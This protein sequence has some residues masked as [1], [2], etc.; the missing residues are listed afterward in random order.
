[1]KWETLTQ[2]IR[3]RKHPTRKRGVKF[4]RYFSIY[5]QFEGKRKEEGIGW[6]SEGWTEERVKILY[7]E[8]KLNR[9]LGRSPMT[10]EEYVNMEK[11][12]QKAKRDE[13]IKRKIERLTIS[14]LYDEYIKIA[15]LNKSKSTIRREKYHFR[16]YI[17]PYIGNK[18]LKDVTVMD[19]EEIKKRALDK[20][21]AYESVNLILATIRQMFNFAIKNFI[22]PG[23]NP[24]SLVNKL[25]GDNRRMRFLTEEE[26]EKLLSLLK[27]KSEKVYRMAMISLYAGLRAGEIFNLKWS[28]IDLEN[29]LIY[30][31]D[32]KNKKN[33]VAF[34]GP[35]IKKLF[36]EM[37]KGKPDE[38]LFKPKQGKKDKIKWVSKTFSR[39]VEE[40]GLNNGIDDP[41]QKVVFHTLR[42][43]FA[44]WLVK[45]TGNI[46]LVKELLGHKT[47][48]MTERYSHLSAD[49]LR[50]AVHMLSK[51][52]NIV[53]L[54]KA[55]RVK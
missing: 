32:P 9:K 13:E 29:E 30:I 28:D 46:Y 48:T 50:Q 12:Q 23:K 49:T 7:N 51:E 36:L 25:K 33:R 15:E 17:Q 42:H 14:E 41:R 1:M 35:E 27:L 31:R 2:G 21:L 55:R 6:E 10:F 43:T 45:K 22:Y 4:D 44:S 18:A 34:M 3:F 52:S 5:Y 8:L 38:P 54:D 16:D 20:G 37:E 53:P 47:L 19:I 11:E 26:A 39:A 24:V 40:L